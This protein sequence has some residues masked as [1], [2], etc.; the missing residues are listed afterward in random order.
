MPA[1]IAN[2]VIFDNIPCKTIGLR[3][4]SF[5]SGYNDS[6]SVKVEFNTASDNNGQFFKT[7]KRK[8]NPLTFSFEMCKINFK[9]INI[10]EQE[11]YRRVFE[12]EDDYKVIQFY[13]KDHENLYFKC[14]CNV[15]LVV[16]GGQVKG[17][18][19]NCTCDSLYGYGD[20]VTE[21]FKSNSLEDS[22][23]KIY[24]KNTTYGMTYPDL[25]IVCTN[26][27]DISIIN[28]NDIDIN[29]NV[30]EFKINNCINGEKI[31]FNNKTK[32]ITTNIK[33]HDIYNDNFSWNYFRLINQYDKVINN[34]VLRGDY[35]LNISYNPKRKVGV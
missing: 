3:L 31:N 7:G 5:D 29:G 35:I 28:L 23:I 18:K 12:R 24:D 16:K 11:Y 32:N 19:V 2:E 14:F 1:I 8:D 22:H 20:I 13:Q 27:T 17:L 10:Y 25:Q 21:E 6:N 33:S 26:D 30:R 15:D 4:C 9:P 34:I